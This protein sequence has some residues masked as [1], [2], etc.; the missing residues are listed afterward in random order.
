MARGRRSGPQ[1]H[2]IAILE[3]SWVHVA[4]FAIV[5]AAPGWSLSP[6]SR[7]LPTP[8]NGVGET[9]KFKFCCF[10]RVERAT[11]AFSG[12]K[13]PLPFTVPEEP[14]IGL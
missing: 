5:T 4:A 9:L 1:P 12:M 2:G 14:F 13:I 10:L 7:R 8:I 6:S 11:F 3:R